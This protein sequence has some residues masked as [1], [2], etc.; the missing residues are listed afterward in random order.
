MKAHIPEKH[1][2]PHR[3]DKALQY[4]GND[5]FVTILKAHRN[6]LEQV[7]ENQWQFPLQLF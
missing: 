5:R 4:E 6:L 3:L 2:K 7:N 1:K